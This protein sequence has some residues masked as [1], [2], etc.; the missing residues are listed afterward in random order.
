[1]TTIETS[2][3][4]VEVATLRAWLEVGRPV[5]VLDVRPLA[6]RA[7]W[8]IPGSRHV[9]AYA[10]LAAGD[11][12]ALAA[13]ELP[14]D[15]PVVTVCGVG[16]TSAVAAEQL[17]ARGLDARSLAGGM[18]AWS[19]AWNVAEL[20]V[21]GSP[22]RVIQAR[23]AGKGC[24]SYLIGV[25]GEAAVIDPSLEP[26]V[27]LTLA[28]ARG[29]RIVRV[30]ET[31]IHA[32]HLSRARRLAETAG[33]TLCLPALAVERVAFPFAPLGEGEALALGSAR[34]AT[35]VTPG[36]TPE[37][38]C[39]RLDDTA[40][41]TGDTLF[42]DGVG[43]PDLHADAATAR[44]K[45]RALFASLRRV[46]AL[47]PATLVLP[48]HAS[49]PVAFDGAPLTA[50]LGDLRARIELL[51]LPEAAFIERLLARLPATPPNHERIVA[52]NQA[53]RFPA[54]D[55]TELEA[56]ANRCAVA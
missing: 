44:A 22:A 4:T 39:Y 54:G 15:R 1:M 48:G 51:R 52:L 23:R 50:T 3:P 9:D 18:R 41:F 17:R 14:A 19:L 42:L 26:A 38:A 5:T 10:A 40:L 12:R 49:R 55:P 13:V 21:P 29:W 53:G 28:Q 16:K 32:D 2:A 36:H 8:F 33:A 37:S 7:E 30:L 24:L 25:D 46:L 27:Y 11:P 45:A 56:G 31:H 6:D 20:V 47:P 43:R 35:L 34:L